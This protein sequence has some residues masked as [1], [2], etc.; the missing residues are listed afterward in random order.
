MLSNNFY[1]FIVFEKKK[2]GYKGSLQESIDTIKDQIS[3]PIKEVKC[4][5]KKFSQNKRGLIFAYNFSR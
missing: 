4:Q 1:I 3:S 2:N 5:I